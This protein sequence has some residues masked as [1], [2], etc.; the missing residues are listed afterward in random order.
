[1]MEN[2]LPSAQ[3]IWVITQSAMADLIQLNGPTGNPSYIW[4]PNARDGIPGTLLGLPVI[5]TEKSPVIGVDGDVLLADWRYYL[6]GDRQAVTVEST[7]FDRW[8]YDETSWR[9]V[10]RVDGQPWL[11]APLTLQDGATQ[12]SPFVILGGKST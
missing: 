5:W 7:Q 8:R 2:F 4:Q 11:S 3:G 9:M 6:L 12:V 1:M 10:H